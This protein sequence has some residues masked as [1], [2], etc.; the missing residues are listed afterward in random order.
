MLRT[1]NPNPEDNPQKHNIGPYYL[2]F[3][4]QSV[5]CDH[6]SERQ[7]PTPQCITKIGIDALPNFQRDGH[8]PKLPVQVRHR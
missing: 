8:R 7:W 2:A 4:K 5:Q 3:D 1:I 6:G